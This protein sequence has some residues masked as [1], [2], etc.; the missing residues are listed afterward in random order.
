MHNY[1]PVV[2]GGLKHYVSPDRGYEIIWQLAVARGRSESDA[3]RE[4]RELLKRWDGNYTPSATTAPAPVKIGPD[5]ER[6]KSIVSR[7]S[8]AVYD[9][10]EASPMRFDERDD[11][12]AHY[13]LSQLFEPDEIIC[14]S[15][16]KKGGYA[17]TI[18]ELLKRGHRFE[19][20]SYIVPNPLNSRD[21]TEGHT[22]ARSLDNVAYR[23]WLVLEWD[24]SRFG[25]DGK[26]PTFWKPLIED[27][28]SRGISIKDAQ[29]TLIDHMAKFAKPAMIVDFAGKSLHTWFPALGMTDKFL[30]EFCRYA[31]LLGANDATKT[32]SQLVRMPGGTRETIMTQP[33]I[34]FNLQLI[35][36]N[37]RN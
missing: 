31:V 12:G 34:Y 8:V 20:E 27:W 6:I 1:L 35:N 9:L 24:I 2:A 15:G 19:F 4:A 7:S 32:I 17:G 33:I 10:W 26:T 28:E 11:S 23:R 29:A 13:A 18:R 3:R 36:S 30:T 21:A 5:I 14:V 16:H 37:K 22:L 25:R